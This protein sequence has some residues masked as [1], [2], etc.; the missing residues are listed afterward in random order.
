MCGLSDIIPDMPLKSEHSSNCIHHNI[1]M[2]ANVY[3]IVHTAIMAVCTLYMNNIIY[4][5]VYVH[6]C[7]C[8]NTFRDVNLQYMFIIVCLHGS[9]YAY[10]GGYACMHSVHC[11]CMCIQ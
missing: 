8:R 1:T 5:H 10:M 6:T 9:K 11:T 2:A 3:T 4:I 7:T